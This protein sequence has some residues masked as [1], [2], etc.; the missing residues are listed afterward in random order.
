[1]DYKVMWRNIQQG[2]S[3]SLTGRYRVL[4]SLPPAAWEVE[5]GQSALARKPDIPDLAD[6]AR[7]AK[8]HYEAELAVYNKKVR[9]LTQGEA[10]AQESPDESDAEAAPQAVALLPPAPRAADIDPPFPPNALVPYRADIFGL[11]RARNDC[12]F[13]MIK[14]VREVR[15][16]VYGPRRCG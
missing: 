2:A 9:L 3:P 10:G 11:D 8:E 6:L 12:R 4:I 16:F 15:R 7:E 14:I 5:Q 1:M 13:E